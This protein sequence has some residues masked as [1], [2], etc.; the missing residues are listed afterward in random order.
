MIDKKKQLFAE[1]NALKGHILKNRTL[2]ESESIFFGYN[3]K[4][5]NG[6]VKVEDF[7]KKEFKDTQKDG[8]MHIEYGKQDIY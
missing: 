5:L 2:S 4:M 3:R 1:L 7:Y 6:N 8:W